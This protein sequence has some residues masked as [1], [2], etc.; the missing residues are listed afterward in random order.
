M[1]S[2]LRWCELAVGGAEWDAEALHTSTVLS[3]VNFVPTCSAP[4]QDIS[5]ASP[6]QHQAQRTLVRWEAD[7]KVDLLDLLLE[8]VFLV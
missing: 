6:K 1:E 5:Q 4:P 3:H 2:S 8:K 7:V